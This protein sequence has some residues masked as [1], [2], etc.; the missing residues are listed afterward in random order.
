MSRIRLIPMIFIALVCLGILISGWQA[1]K[2]FNMVQPLKAQLEAVA[3]VKNVVVDVG[4][5][6]TIQVKLGPVKDL[7]TTYDSILTKVDG[8]LGGTGAITLVDNRDSTLTAAWESL[9]PILYEGLRKGNYTEMISAFD[10]KAAK[11]GIRAAVTMDTRNVYVQLSKGSHYLYTVE[12]YSL[13]Q[14]GAAS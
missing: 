14:G 10:T 13:N 6:S 12:P 1:Y 2:R 11:E 7:Q 3:G 9:S 5:P 8:Q 4:N